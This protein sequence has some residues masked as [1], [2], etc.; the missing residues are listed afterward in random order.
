M[1]CL[2]HASCSASDECVVAVIAETLLVVAL[3]LILAVVLM[4]M[5]DSVLVIVYVFLVL[6][7]MSSRGLS[8]G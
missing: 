1:P 7:V 3:A 6:H 8:C 2:P 5:L 4:V